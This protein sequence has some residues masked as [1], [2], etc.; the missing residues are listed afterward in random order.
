MTLHP[1][2]AKISFTGTIATGKSIVAN[3]AKTLKR[4]TLE[5]AGNDAAIVAD[6]VDVGEVAGRAATGCFFNAGQMCVAT[7]RVYVHE[8]RYD[9]FLEKFTNEVKKSFSV[10]S[11]AT[12]PSLFDPVSN[13]MQY[14]SVK[15]FADH[16]KKNGY[17]VIATELP[18]DSKGFWVPPTIVTK[19]P[20]DSIL[21]QEERF[22]PI[23][24]ILTWTDEEEVI[25]R[26]NLSNAGLGASVY[27][28]A[29][30]RAESIA[31]KIEA[32]T[33]SINAPELPNVGGYFAGMKDSGHGGEMGKQGLLSYCYTQ[34]LHFAKT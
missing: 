11:D 28:R 1:G 27:C 14:N 25:Q 5:L 29:V 15:E 30:G 9:E 2:I 21:V 24:P 34:S 3:C 10:K 12:S 16:Y 18:L 17:S 20:E 8:S 7:K 4:L 6:D 31:R 32:G 22:G 19:P 33:V 13:K 23:L 26:A